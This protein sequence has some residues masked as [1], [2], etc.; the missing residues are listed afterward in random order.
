MWG[1]KIVVI[2]VWNGDKVTLFIKI[3]YF[4]YETEA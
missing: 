1:W 2:Y 3:I 4:V